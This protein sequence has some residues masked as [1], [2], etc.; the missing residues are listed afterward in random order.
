MQL[1][2]ALA[3]LCGLARKRLLIFGERERKSAGLLAGSRES[4]F[5]LAHDAPQSRT[6]SMRDCDGLTMI[7][8]RCLE[9]LAF[10]SQR[11][12]LRRGEFQLSCDQLQPEPRILKLN[13][14]R[15]ESPPQV[16]SSLASLTSSPS[17]S[18]SDSTSQD[19]RS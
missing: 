5:A 11:L 16:Q 18:R 15:V 19:S 6:L 13:L 10:L 7:A 3:Q 14:L 1:L 4:L 8:Q 2:V 9:P 17:E 12:F